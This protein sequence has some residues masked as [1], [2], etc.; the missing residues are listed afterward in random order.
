MVGKKRWLTDSRNMPLK[1]FPTL[2]SREQPG[3]ER[4]KEYSEIYVYEII[5]RDGPV[6]KVDT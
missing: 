2:F 4:D 6:G 5:I 1:I 3:K